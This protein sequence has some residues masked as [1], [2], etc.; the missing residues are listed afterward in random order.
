MY[1]HKSRLAGYR[2]SDGNLGRWQVAKET[3]R[4]MRDPL[5][6]QSYDPVSGRVAVKGNARGARIR[7]VVDA[8][9]GQMVSTY[10]VIPRVGA[11]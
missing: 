4:A 7:V 1:D 11:R 8:R 3:S 10:P 6:S 5:R 2:S 9:T